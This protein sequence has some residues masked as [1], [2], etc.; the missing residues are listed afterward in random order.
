[1]ISRHGGDVV[2]QLCGVLS[3]GAVIRCFGMVPKVESVM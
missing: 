2:W 3:N 1:M